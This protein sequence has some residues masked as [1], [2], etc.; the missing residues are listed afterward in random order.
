[1]PF[2][3]M[4]PETISAW[5]ISSA[6]ALTT[7]CAGAV[8]A[9]L[10]VTV[11]DIGDVC[12][13]AVEALSV[14]FSS[15]EY[16]S[17]TVSVLPEMAQSSLAPATAPLPPSTVHSVASTWTPPLTETSHCQEYVEVPV[18]GTVPLTVSAWSTSSAVALE[19]GTPG[20]VS[21]DFTATVEEPAE[22]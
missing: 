10:T 18:E 9:E 2:D 17:P 16:E 20:V 14:T 7:G 19:E 13:S 1:M 6:D 8:S 5:S 12:V 15:K 22:F 4:M 11:V 3:G 21:A